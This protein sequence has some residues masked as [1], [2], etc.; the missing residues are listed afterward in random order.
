MASPTVARLAVILCLSLSSGLCDQ[1]IYPFVGTL[2][3]HE[4]DTEYFQHQFPSIKNNYDVAQMDPMTFRA[5]LEGFPDLPRWMRY[6]Q[7]SPTHKA[8]LYGSPTET[9]KQVIEVT[10]YN[11]Q[12][13]E[14]VKQRFI[15]NILPSPALQTPFQAEFL[16]ANLDVE[17]M[18][19]PEAQLDFQAPLQAVWG[20][21]RTTILNITSALDKGGRVPLPLPGH[22]EG[23]F[24]KLGS[25]V[26][27]SDCLIESQAIEARQLCQKRGQPILSCNNQ[28]ANR[29]Q[30]DWC[31]TSLIYFSAPLPTQPPHLYSGIMDDESEFNP[32]SETLEET[33]YLTDYLLTLLLPTLIALLLCAFLSYIMCC[34]REG[35]EKRDGE[36]SAIQLVHQQSIFSNTEELRHMAGNR[37]V[38]RPLSTL[39]MFNVRTGERASPRQLH[40]DSA[41]VPLILSQH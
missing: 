41:R 20:A 9:G 14:T 18:L 23:V 38:P 26:P 4:L 36:T 2:F 32:P 31:N 24:I 40:D 10:A 29:F 11:R 22:K 16:I 5:N 39:P 27:F 17:E 34:R 25:D 30:I 8:Y 37:D 19:P 7:R 28:F 12:T 15:F 33:Y 21:Q 3:V 35:I 6:T 13:F 1:I